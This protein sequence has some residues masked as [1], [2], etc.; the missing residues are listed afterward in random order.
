M[1][2]GMVLTSLTAARRPGRRRSRRARGPGSPA[3]GRPRPPCR[4]AARPRRRRA[5]RARRTRRRRRGTWRR[6]R[7]RR[8]SPTMRISAGR[9]ARTVPSGSSST[10]HS[11][12]RPMIA[13][14]DQHLRVVLRGPWRS[15]RRASAQSVTRVMPTEDPARAGLTN[16]G[17]PS[18]S[19]SAAVSVAVPRRST[20]RSPTGRPSA[21]QQLLRELLVHAR[22]AGQH[23]GPDVGQ[24]GHLQQPLDRAVLAER[25]VQHGEHDVHAGEHLARAARLEDDQPGAR[26]VAGQH[27][28]RC[29]DGVDGRQRAAVDRQLRGV[30]G[31]QHPGAVGGDADRDDVEAVAVEVAQHAAGRDAGDGV[32]AAAAAE[33]DRHADTT[34]HRRCRHVTQGRGPSVVQPE[35]AQVA[36]AEGARC[37]PGR[38]SGCAGRRC[39]NRCA[40]A[41]ARAPRR[42][43]R[44]A[45]PA[46]SSPGARPSSAS[47]PPRAAAPPARP[48]PPARSA[49][50]GRAGGAGAAGRARSSRAAPRGRARSCGRERCRARR[51]AAPARPGPRRAPARGAG[52]GGPRPPPA[53]RYGPRRAG[54][55]RRRGA[56]GGCRRRARAG[57]PACAPTSGRR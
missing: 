17:R 23:P 19:R 35:Q 24:A 36:R 32:L 27:Q 13:G 3:R 11:I 47:S 41:R 4:A 43:D 40:R 55:A 22:G 26:R 38:R 49:A 8:A 6:S 31:A 44:S 54:R 53:G 42:P 39:R 16:T 51:S 14:L 20:T 48:R 18:R 7:R 33:H 52:H 50:A 9:L 5:W 29:A 12:S 10:P 30:V 34:R 46:P 56:A 57:C 28:R 21:R 45:A 25:A 2:P 1:K 15:R 37:R